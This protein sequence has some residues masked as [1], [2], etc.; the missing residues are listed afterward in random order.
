MRV[1]RSSDSVFDTV[2]RNVVR[3][4]VNDNRCGNETLT[5]GNL[6]TESEGVAPSL[7]RS[8]RTNKGRAD[9]FWVDFLCYVL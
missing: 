7:R 8:S 2:D 1:I 6:T 9:F 3:G 5:G 4:P